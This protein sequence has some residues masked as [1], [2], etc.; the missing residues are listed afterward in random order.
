MSFDQDPFQMPSKTPA[1]Q[2]IAERVPVSG[3]AGAGHG[4]Q[5][6]ARFQ[7]AS[8]ASSG[9]V[10]AAQ[11]GLSGARHT[12]LTPSQLAGSL[13]PATS[14]LGG[15]ETALAAGQ[16]G[17]SEA[18]L[19]PVTSHPRRSRIHLTARAG[20]QKIEVA[21]I[22]SYDPVAN[23]ALVRILGAQANLIGPLPL[24]EGLSPLLAAPGA[25]CLVVLL[26]EANPSDAAIVAIYNAPPQ[27]W[28]QAGTATL[29]LTGYQLAQAV[30]FP[31]AFSTVVPAVTAT[32]RH[33]DFVAVVS[34]ETLGGFMLTVTRREGASQ[35][36]YGAINVTV[37][38]G[39][40]SGS[41]SLAFPSAFAVARSV[42][43]TSATAGWEASVSGLLA[44][45]CLVT[46]SSTSVGPATI[47]VYWQASGDPVVSASVGVDWQAV[48]T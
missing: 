44:S 25:T 18:A 45:G 29:A 12:A 9:H 5:A 41:A 15:P 34:G 24:G 39:A 30:S 21:S 6:W 4:G 26:D 27:S 38:V 11:E 43:A 19:L 7:G 40:S 37:G 36:Q 23:T 20:L 14:S 10:V 35:W 31:A 16:L 48:G 13:L 2:S 32:S 46:V 42:V 28:S 17:G 22:Q 47:A 1:R 33:P 8:R 3:G